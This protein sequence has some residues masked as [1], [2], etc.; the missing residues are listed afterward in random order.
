VTATPAT[1]RWWNERTAACI[2]ILLAT[3]ACVLFLGNDWVG[4]DG[5]R[6]RFDSRVHQWSG[7]WHGFH[8]AYWPPP[9]KGGLYRPLGMTTF[10]LQWMLGGGGILLFRIVNLL[11]YAGAAFAVWRL[12]RRYLP[13][14]PA[15][16]AAALFAVHPLHTEV[17]AVS[18]NQAES[19]V[20]ICAAIAVLLWHDLATG[21]RSARAAVGG[22]VLA[23]LVALGFKEHALV[24]PGLLFASEFA[25]PGGGG[26]R[27]RW[28]ERGKAFVVIAVAGLA[29]WSMRAAILGDVAGAIAAEGLRDASLGHRLVTML[30]VVP[31]WARLFLWPETLRIDYAPMQIDPFATWGRAQTIGVLLIVGWGLALVQGVRRAPI[32]AFG[33]A[34]LAIGIAPMSNVI[35]PTG[36]LLAERTLFLA[37]VGLV[38]MA[39]ALVAAL[40]THWERVG[41]LGRILVPVGGVLLLAAALVRDHRRALDWRDTGTFVTAELRD[42]PRSYH[43]HTAYAFWAYAIGD[44][45]GAEAHLREAIRLWPHHARPYHDLGDFYRSDYLC[46]PALVLYAR[47]IELEPDRRRMRLS[48]VA[49]AVWLGRYAE[50]AAMARGHAPTDVDATRLQVAAQVAD[51]ALAARAPA[52]TVRLATSRDHAGEVGWR[53]P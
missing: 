43:A 52:Q 6:I 50:G 51:S 5:P 38:L 13:L 26:W 40:E 9:S 46:E 28:R 18:V 39:G 10:T 25:L 42:S 2:V 3:L 31:E 16:V 44:K 22:I 27:E 47:G 17:M 36:T 12:A 45:Q 23:Y 11:L 14:L 53:R 30:G 35:M 1:P 34:W 19:V 21:R 29:W 32:L 8:E 4:D 49:C 24:I 37:T 7:L 20:V 15:F 33:A 41:R 48:Y